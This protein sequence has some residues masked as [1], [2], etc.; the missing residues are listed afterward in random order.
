MSIFPFI[1]YE[2]TKK[3]GTDEL[4]LLKE[5]AYDFVKNELLTDNKGRHYMVEGNEALCI[6]IY[7]AL[8]IPRFHYTAYSSDFGTEWQE[9]LVGHTLDGNVLKLEMERFIVEALMVNPY[10][11]SLDNF[12]FV[13]SLSG[14]QVS[15]DCTSVYGRQHLSFQI[16]EVSI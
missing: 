7:K 10:I 9:K 12:S 1:D 2:G 3:G 8:L 15:F 4:P 11:R 14:L 5:Y 16:K 6:W 13:N